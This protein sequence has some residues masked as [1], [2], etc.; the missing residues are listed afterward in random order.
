MFYYG[1]QIAHARVREKMMMT[2]QKKYWFLYSVILLLALGIFSLVATWGHSFIGK[3][4]PGYL[5]QENGVVSPFFSPRWLQIGE[6][7]RYFELSPGLS[8]KQIIFS[9]MDYIV[10]VLFLS[11]SGLLFVML[12]LAV[13]Y[14]YPPFSSKNIL[15][16]I[17]TLAGIYLML[18]VDFHLTHK[19]SYLFLLVTTFLPT[20]ALHFA[21]AYPDHRLNKKQKTVFGAA[22]FLTSLFYPFY[23][24]AF[25]TNPELWLKLQMVLM[26][27]VFFSSLFWIGR[28][29]YLLDRPQHDF[30]KT[31]SLY[32]L[33]GQCL[34]FLV[35]LVP[36]HLLLVNDIFLPLNFFAPLTLLCPAAFFVGLILAKLKQSQWSLVQAERRVTV[37]NLFSGLVHEINNPMTFVYSN[38][39]PVREILGDIKNNLPASAAGLVKKVDVMDGALAD[40]E[41]GANR[42]RDIINQ[43]RFYSHPGADPSPSSQV[44]LKQSI[45]GA[46]LMTKPKWKDRIVIENNVN[47]AMMVMGHSTGLGQLWVNLLSNACD[48]IEGKGTIRIDA[49]EVE[50]GISVFIKDS[51]KGVPPD[52]AKRVFDPFFTTKPQGEG[53]GLGLALCLEIVTKHGGTIDIHSEEGHGC[54]VVVNFPRR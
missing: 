24:F 47:E 54:E 23:V 22:Y 18:T 20:L 45:E 3:E 6:K 35:H 31:L 36:A 32:L 41:T 52:V 9:M 49:K 25:K 8:D 40:M 10:I 7:I 53:T 19:L 37:A 17:N 1:P 13:H 21:L 42:V 27:Y 48:A 15:L 50:K 46:L 33:V 30:V 12:G 38:I 14:F 4:I 2:S 51:G 16:V 26:A 5:T 43:F 29:F 28:L 34:V 11:V 39:E 44:I